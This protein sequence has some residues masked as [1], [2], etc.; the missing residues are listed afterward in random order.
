MAKTKKETKKIDNKVT[1]KQP[2]QPK[3]TKRKGR[4]KGIKLEKNE[5]IISI[6]KTYRLNLSDGKNIAIEKYLT[7][8]R[9]NDGEDEQGNKWSA[10][11]KYTEWTDIGCYNGINNFK[12]AFN[13]L[14]G[15]MIEDGIK[16][17]G[18]V[19]VKEF[20]EIYKKKLDFLEKLFKT[21]FTNK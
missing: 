16:E 21:D 20:Y 6:D 10:G 4:Q 8:T 19:N 7:K 2:T 5:A 11:D 12:A 9:M 18:T 13:D 1:E 17:K 14:H 15:L 3:E